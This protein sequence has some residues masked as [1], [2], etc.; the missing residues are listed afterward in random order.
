MRRKSDPLGR[1]STYDANATRSLDACEGSMERRSQPKQPSPQPPRV[2]SRDIATAFGSALTVSTPIVSR[3]VGGTFGSHSGRW[4]LGGWGAKEKRRARQGAQREH[5]ASA[6]LPPPPPPPH[7][8]GTL[9]AA[10]RARP[11]NALGFVADGAAL[12]RVAQRVGG[13]ETE[14]EPLRGRAE[15]LAGEEFGVGEDGARGAEL[16]R[17]PLGESAGDGAVDRRRPGRSVGVDDQD[18]NRRRCVDAEGESE[19]ERRRRNAG[20]RRF[21]QRARLRSPELFPSR[22]GRRRAA[23]LLPR[24]PLLQH[25]EHDD[26][27]PCEVARPDGE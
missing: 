8:D 11:R 13:G 22:R 21:R 10:T 1:G 23:F 27:A 2:V 18:L 3:D 24:L 17:P 25:D 14:L 26:A 19:G 5:G 6:V 15:E 12:H 16:R 4:Y 20:A 9:N 7:S